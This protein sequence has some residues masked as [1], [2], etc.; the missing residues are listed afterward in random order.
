MKEIRAKLDQ[1]FLRLPPA[2]V[3]GESPLR[4]TEL[5]S[6]ISKEL[7]ATGWADQRATTVKEEVEGDDPYG[8]QKFC[9][10]Y[11]DTDVF[12]RDLRRAIRKSAF[13]HG[14]DENQV[15][16]VFAIE[17]R[18]KLLELAGLEAPE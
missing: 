9:F 8:I 10:E 18:D 7:D 2:T 15:R 12:P 6:A 4:L 11:A 13:Q 14:L 5:G 17:L 16:R 1:I 3:A